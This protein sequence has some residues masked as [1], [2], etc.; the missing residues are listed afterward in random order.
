MKRLYFSKN[1]LLGEFY[2]DKGGKYGKGREFFKAKNYFGLIK[3]LSKEINLK[4][5]A[6]LYVSKNLDNLLIGKLEYFLKESKIILKVVKDLE[7][8]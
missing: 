5:K 7:E 4:R 3:S 1:R 6:V 2:L 8:Y